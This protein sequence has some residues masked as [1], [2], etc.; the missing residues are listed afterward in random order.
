MSAS[1]LRWRDLVPGLAVTAALA[2]VAWA[3]FRYAQVGGM[4][5]DTMELHAPVGSARGIM[6]GSQ[7][8]LAGYAIGKVRSVEFLPLSADTASRVAIKLE[9][10][11]R[12]RDQLRRDSYA[13]IRSGANLI[14][15][16]VVFL[17][18]GTPGSPLL[19]DGDT[20]RTRPQVDP[21]SFSSQVALASRSFPEIIAN[22][23]VLSAQLETTEGTLGA[24]LGDNSGRLEVVSARAGQVARKL[25]G[26]N[27][28]VG[29][30]LGPGGVMERAAEVRASADSLRAL[31]A[32]D[33]GA[34]GRFRR[35]STLAA[36]VREVL[37][38]VSIVRALLAEPRGTA[39]RALHDRAAYD[40]IARLERELGLL[41]EDIKR[42]PLR[43]VVF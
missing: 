1:S 25:G 42:R 4:R 38:E 23:K 5:G 20:L 3:V 24:L 11:S 29:R 2:L 26:G 18:S 7:V 43:Y 12:F 17:T 33:A 39:G 10:L 8:W 14:G 30:A 31:V 28:T 35:D 16:P 37:D 6:R 22:V 36:Q 13:Q 34:L 32:G 21:E 19:A 41:M 15:A 9:V 40:E 27:G